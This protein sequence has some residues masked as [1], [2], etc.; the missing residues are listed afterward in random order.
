[1]LAICENY[2]IEYGYCNSFNAG[3]SKCLVGCLI[4]VAFYVAIFKNCTFH[5][6]KNPIEYI[7]SFAHLGH[8]IWNQLTDIIQRRKSIYKPI[9][10]TETMDDQL[11]RPHS[12]KSI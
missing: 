4:I 8:V 12:H 7:D 10:T 3:K 11:W 5:F 2:A 6:S 1:M 9:S